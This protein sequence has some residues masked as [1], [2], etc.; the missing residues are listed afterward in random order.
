M[1][2]GEPDEEDQDQKDQ[3]RQGCPTAFGSVFRW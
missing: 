2:G 1:K 3:D